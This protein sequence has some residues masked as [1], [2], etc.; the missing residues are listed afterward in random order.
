MVRL[1]AERTFA[2]VDPKVTAPELDYCDFM[3]L[4]LS[5]FHG[6]RDRFQ[7]A[8][9][10]SQN[11]SESGE[12]RVQNCETAWRYRGDGIYC[13]KEVSVFLR[14]MAGWTGLDHASDSRRL[15]RL[16]RETGHPARTE[17]SEG[18]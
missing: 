17:R 14:V 2:H 5:A 10:D 7:D 15:A 9:H 4:S 1:T 18:R 11:S 8:E 12:S 16:D 13:Q 6:G 3:R